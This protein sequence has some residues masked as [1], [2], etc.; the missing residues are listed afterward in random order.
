[1]KQTQGASEESR[2]VAVFLL[3]S[4]KNFPINFPCKKKELGPCKQQVARKG[5]RRTKGFSCFDF[6]KL[7]D[8]SA[9]L[10]LAGPKGKAA[11]QIVVTPRPLLPSPAMPGP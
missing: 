5:E 1:M 11:P 10:P 6:D 4:N 2:R 7:V 9:V 8:E 3:K